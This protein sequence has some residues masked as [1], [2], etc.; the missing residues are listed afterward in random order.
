MSLRGD[1]SRQSEW[2]ILY[3]LVVLRIDEDPDDHG[4][5][6]PPTGRRNRHPEPTDIVT[7]YDI[8]PW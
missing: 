8:W 6:G 3:R 1:E 4:S 7:Q 5:A 2:C